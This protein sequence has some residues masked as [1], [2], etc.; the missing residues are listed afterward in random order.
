MLYQGNANTVVAI[1]T[2]PHYLLWWQCSNG[3]HSDTSAMVAP[4]VSTCQCHIER[5]P[6]VAIVLYHVRYAASH[7]RMII[8]CVI[9]TGQGADGLRLTQWTEPLRDLGGERL[10]THFVLAPRLQGATTREVELV[11]ERTGLP[12]GEV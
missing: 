2:L 12:G 10:D 11:S 9:T 8:V 1:V 7:H 5:V 6:S 4:V 3:P